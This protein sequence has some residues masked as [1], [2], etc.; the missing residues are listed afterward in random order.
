MNEHDYKLVLATALMI[1]AALYLL[2]ATIFLIARLNGGPTMNITLVTNA[3]QENL[4]EIIL[5]I[6]L[7]AAC[8]AL[9]LHELR[10]AKK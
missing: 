3:Y 1:S 4:A 6:A 2:F 10:G 5:L 8:T 7:A 9:A